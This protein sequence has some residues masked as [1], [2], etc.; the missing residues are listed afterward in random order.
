MSETPINNE[1]AELESLLALMADDQLSVDEAIRLELLIADNSDTRRQYIEMA[2]LCANIEWAC[3]SHAGAPMAQGMQHDN[4]QTLL[5]ASGMGANSVWQLSAAVVVGAALAA[6]L[7][8]FSSDVVRPPNDSSA[9][10][11]TAPPNSQASV[12]NTLANA[13][14]IAATL[15]G[16]VDCK[17]KSGSAGPT[18]GEQLRNNRSLKL[19]SGLAQLTFESG[20][21]LILQGPAEFVIRS[22]MFGTLNVG[23][24]TA[25]V[26]KQAH[27]FTVTTPSAEVIDLG[28]EFG[29]EVDVKG[30]TEVHVFEGEVLSWQVGSEGQVEGEAMSL[31]K[32]TGAAYTI[33]AKAPECLPAT[34]GHFIREVSPRLTAEQ[35]PQLPVQHDLALWLAADVLVKKDE[36]N[37]VIAWRDIL[38]GDN[39]MA[40]DAWQHEEPHRPLWVDNAIGGKPALRFDGRSRYMV[41]TPL[42]TTKDQTLFFVFQRSSDTANKFEQRQLI[43]YNGPP[44]NL[45]DP[46]RTFRILQIDDT[47]RAGA[48]RALVYGGVNRSRFVCFGEVRMPKP[49]AIGTPLVLSY[50]FNTKTNQAELIVNSVSQGTATAP[51]GMDVVSRKIIGK[52]PLAKAFFHGDMAEVLIYNAS[53]PSK[54]VAQ[55]TRYLSEKYSIPKP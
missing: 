22:D 43:N 30:R 32:D 40:E 26:P 8:L 45:S 31:I 21:K 25:V 55:I 2:S 23:K 9:A 53:L 3:G 24:L 4:E 28:T 27:G 6:A 15:S 37:R 44:F 14:P 48:Y 51:S 38:I 35:L 33:G 49:T 19:S 39:Q 46:S 20:A 12:K 54:Q 10:S 42:P 41:T 52:H 1:S 16:L 50:T 11:S 17:W 47:G 34:S 13:P 7:F 36:Q 18:Y 5:K 29:I